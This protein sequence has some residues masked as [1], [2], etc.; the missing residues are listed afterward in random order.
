MKPSGFINFI[1]GFVLIVVFHGC[2]RNEPLNVILYDKPIPLIEYYVNGEWNLK[3]AYGGLVAQKHVDTVNTQ[4]SLKSNHIEIRNDLQ[5]V[6]VDTTYN[7]VKQDIGNDEYIFLLTYYW[8]GN[9]FPEYIFF[10]RIKC[11]TLILR[12]YMSDGYTYYYTK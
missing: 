11:D 4:L 3:Y 1:I 7:W 6:I 12:D 8:R 5:G 9:V 10:D 2:D